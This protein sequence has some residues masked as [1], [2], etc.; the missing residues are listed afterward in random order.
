LSLHF[1]LFTLHQ[2]LITSLM[3]TKIISKFNTH[4]TCFALIALCWDF[5]LCGEFLQNIRLGT[6]I[7]LRKFVWNVIVKVEQDSLL[8]VNSKRDHTQSSSWQLLYLFSSLDLQWG[9]LN[10]KVKFCSKIMSI[11]HICILVDK[12]GTICGIQCG[13]P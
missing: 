2:M 10:C 1:V 4:W 7:K 9:L 8:S 6:M 3:C 11:D 12:T 5:I 13:V